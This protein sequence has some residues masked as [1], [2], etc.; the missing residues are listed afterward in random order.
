MP[1]FVDI[2][3]T[4]LALPTCTYLRKRTLCGE[5]SEGRYSYHEWKINW[6][7]NVFSILAKYVRSQM[8]RQTQSVY[9][10]HLFLC[11]FY[12]YKKNK[13]ANERGYPKIVLHSK[14]YCKHGCDNIIICP[15]SLCRRYSSAQNIFS[16]YLMQS[17]RMRFVCTKK[18]NSRILASIN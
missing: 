4:N 2:W 15:Y 8:A 11:G 3:Y 18:G 9:A 6:R 16:I 7:W 13:L 5:L 1:H 14:L 17:F 10:V 12:K